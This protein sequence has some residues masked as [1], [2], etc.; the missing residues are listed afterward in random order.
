MKL[1]RFSPIEDEETL[2]DAIRYVILSSSALCRRAIHTQ[3]PITS[4]TI[5]AH[6]PEEFA[7]LRTILDKI[8]EPFNENNGPRI[9]LHKPL[10]IEQ[11]VITKL[12]V[13]QPDPYRMQVGCND[14][15]VPNYDEF[16]A[17]YLTSVNPHLRLIERPDYEM[18]EFFDPDS[19]VLAY[20]LNQ[21]LLLLGLPEV[22]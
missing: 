13:R 8:G 9:T 5:F 1:Y 22:Q 14:F 16:K 11:N 2:K 18:V 17:K 12:R 6:Y 20:V 19:D 21:E 15:D 4:L 10:A 7:Y 3:L